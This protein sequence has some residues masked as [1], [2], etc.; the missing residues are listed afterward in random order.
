MYFNGPSSNRQ[1][2]QIRRFEQALDEGRAKAI[3]IAESV[4]DD[5]KRSRVVGLARRVHGPP[6]RCHLHLVRN[7]QGL[8]RSFSFHEI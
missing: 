4:A 2:V 8:T 3:D 7:T 6:G 1:S 5:Q